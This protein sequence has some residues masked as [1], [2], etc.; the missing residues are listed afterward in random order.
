MWSEGNTANLCIGQEITVTPIQMAVM[1][2]AVANGGKVF[3]PRLVQRIEP[4]EGGSDSTDLTQF[5]PRVRS[6]LGVSAHSLEVV[7]E[8]MLADVEDADGTGRAAAVSGLRVCGKTGTAQ[9][10][11]FDHGQ[12][13]PGRDTWF[14]SYAPYDNPRWAVI[15]LVVDGHSGGGTCAPIARQ[16]YQMLQKRDQANIGPTAAALAEAR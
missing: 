12:V 10:K 14:A 3:W 8:A 1:V 5:P 16:V 6:E 15:V 9:T 11:H 7:R 13:V 4:Q 2:S